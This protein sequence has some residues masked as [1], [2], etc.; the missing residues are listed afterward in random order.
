[1][2]GRAAGVVFVLALAAAPGCYTGSA[3]NVSAAGLNVM[4]RD[5]AWRIVDDVPFVSQ[6]TFR[7]CGPAALAMVLAHF[8]VPAPT[9]ERPEFRQGDVRAGTLRDVARARGLDAFVVAG[10]FDDIATQVGRGRPV[11]VGLAKPM[12]LTGGRALAHYE[13][14]IGFNRSRRLILSLDPATGLRE[15]TLEG[16]AREWVPTGQ[17]TI[18]VLPRAGGPPGVASAASSG[19]G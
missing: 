13:V 19:S 2:T 3:H 12:A 10:T 1:V 15:N 6:R 17:V 8:R 18:I 14:V 11:L 7:D 5:P 4:T 16:F 9:D